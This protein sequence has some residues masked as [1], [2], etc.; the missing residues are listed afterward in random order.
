RR[1][2]APDLANARSVECTASTLSKQ[3]LSWKMKLL[4]AAM[5]VLT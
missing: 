2:M 1:V 3:W 4:D 5:E